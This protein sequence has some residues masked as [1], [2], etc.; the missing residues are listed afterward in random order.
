MSPAGLEHPRQTLCHGL[1]WWV[2]RLALGFAEKEQ[3]MNELSQAIQEAFVTNLANAM[4][5]VAEL[6]PNTLAMLVVLGVGYILARVLDRVVVAV[7]NAIGVQRAAE[8]SGLVTSMNEVGIKHSVPWIL[9]KIVFWLTMCV[10]LSAGFSILGLS[11]VELALQQ[12]VE[13]IPRLL[14]ATVVIVIGL[15]VAGFL[16]GVIAT[17]A[18]RLG[19]SYAETLASGFYYVLALLTFMAAFDQLGIQFKLLEDMM[20]IAFGALGVGFA[21]AFGLGGREVMGGILAGYYTRQ[22]LHAGDHVRVAD[23]EGTVREVG[24][25]ATIIETDEDGLLH[26]HSIPNSKMLSEAVR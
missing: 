22:R 11:A 2:P 10:F 12:I 3:T 18:D 14:V 7:G 21:L 4:G 9:G 13:Y 23:L 26:R 1:I 19:F 15:M 5:R 16:R 24:P 6:A 25:V 17:G 8:R 20:L